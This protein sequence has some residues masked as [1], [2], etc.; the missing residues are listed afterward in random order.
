MLSWRGSVKMGRYE[1]TKA[2][3]EDFEN[4]FE[5][6]IDTFG[7]DQALKYHNGMKQ[8]FDELAEQPKLYPAVDHIR[9]GYRR[10]VYG[11]H[12]IYYRIKPRRVLIVRIL[13]RQDPDKAF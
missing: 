4:M 1:L 8:R 10:S 5:Y 11:S 2:A 3:A 12:S 13:G 9:T 7:L 6:G